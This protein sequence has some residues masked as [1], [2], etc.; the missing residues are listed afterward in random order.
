MW[1]LYNLNVDIAPEFISTEELKA[2]IT[3]WFD[4]PWKTR[5]QVY[6]LPSTPTAIEWSAEQEPVLEQ[7]EEKTQRSNRPSRRPSRFLRSLELSI[8]FADGQSL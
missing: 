1:P 7:V 5:S 8:R 2:R 6:F 3:P 4:S